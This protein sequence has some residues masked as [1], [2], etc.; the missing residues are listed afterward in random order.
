M[1]LR[2]AL[3]YPRDDA[4]GIEKSAQAENVGREVT[5]SVKPDPCVQ[6]FGLALG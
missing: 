2:P 5:P 4:F 1:W 6:G 3:P